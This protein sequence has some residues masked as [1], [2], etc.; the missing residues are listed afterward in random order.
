MTRRQGAAPLPARVA[1]AGTILLFL[2][3][4][5]LFAQDEPETGLSNSTELSWVALTGNSKSN[6]FGVRNV[7]LYKWPNAYFEWEFGIVRA[8]S[9]DGDRF[10]LGTEDDFEIVEPLTKIDSNRVYN[11]MRYARDLSARFFWY[12]SFNSDRDE[13]S[14]LNFRFTPAGGAGNFWKKTEALVFQTGYGI[15]YTSE[16]L[17]LEG[18]SNFGGYQLFYQLNATVRERTTIESNLTFDG[19]F[20]EADN[21]RFDWLNG[22]VD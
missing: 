22:A 6:T 3:A 4:T 11:R 1:I 10:A 2:N 13:P 16:D 12:A 8:S 17:D 14:N 21:H 18:T 9:R 15:S 5:P 7:F 19:S 20:K